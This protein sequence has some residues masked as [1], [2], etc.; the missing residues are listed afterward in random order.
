MNED[1]P[2]WV[3]ISFGIT[4]MICGALLIILLP[5][6]LKT[7]VGQLIILLIGLGLCV[8]GS[9]NPNSEVK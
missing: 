7:L 5:F 6:G 1:K 2:N 3:L 9:P 4:L 8:A